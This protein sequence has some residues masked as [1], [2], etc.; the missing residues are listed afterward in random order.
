MDANLIVSLAI[1]LLFLLI[2]MR[3]PVGL[4]LSASGLLG[5]LLLRDLRVVE[6]AAASVPYSSTAR[7]AYIVVPMFIL[8]GALAN[9]SGLASSIFQ[10]ASRVLRRLPGGLG[11]ASVLTCGLFAAISGSSVATVASIGPIAVR[12]MRLR[13]YAP[14]FAA[15]IIAGSGTLGVLIPPSIVLV[16]YAIIS[17]EPVS[18]MLLAG[19]LPGVLSIAVFSFIVIFRTIRTQTILT[20]EEAGIAT[21]ASGHSSHAGQGAY[22]LSTSQAPAMAQAPDR[23]VALSGAGA[24]L[25]VALVFTIVIGGLYT[26]FFTATEA[27]ALGA[28]SVFL[29]ALVDGKR[30]GFGRLVRQVRDAFAEAAALSSMAFFVVM[31]AAIFSFFLVSAR[32]PAELSRWVLDLGVA[33]WLVVVLLLALMIPLG[34]FLDALSSLLIIVPLAHPIVT[35]LGFSG[36]WFGILMVKMVE[37]GM[38]TPPVGLNV[39]VMAGAVRDLKVEQVFRGVSW[40]I[41]GD[42]VIVAILFTIPEIVLIVPELADA[43]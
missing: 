33:P 11:V 13:G 9:Q 35:E 25:R 23:T 32:T 17:G 27:S 29:L 18:A 34:M 8:M 31:G 2:L 30:V 16:L 42:L 39:F 19:F 24:L 20:E 36:I 41:L 4:A 12:E 40:F 38:I 7:Y 1:G 5:L 21:A 26:G 10:L 14:G 37:L 22:S 28:L 6:A 3:V 43:L 15:G